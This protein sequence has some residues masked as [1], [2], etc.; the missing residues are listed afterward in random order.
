[1]TNT[2][3]DRRGERA[4]STP[5][6]PLTNDHQHIQTLEHASLFKTGEIDV[7]L[8]D[9]SKMFLDDEIRKKPI[10]SIKASHIAN[11][12]VHKRTEAVFE[13]TL[14]GGQ[15]MGHYFAGAFKSLCL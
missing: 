3:S 15:F 6:L 10:V 11:N 13:V 2:N 12:T 8:F 9:A 7:A 4:R 1:M 5:G 14:Q